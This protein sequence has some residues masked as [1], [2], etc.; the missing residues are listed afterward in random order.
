MKAELSQSGMSEEEILHKT[1]VLMKAFGKEDKKAGLAEFSLASKQKNSA[2]RK[3]D[4][5]PKD[6]SQVIRSIWKR[7]LQDE[8]SLEYNQGVNRN[9]RKCRKDEAR[10]GA[11]LKQFEQAL[12]C[13]T[14][15]ST[16]NKFGSQKFCLW[17]CYNFGQVFQALD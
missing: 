2:L 14:S 13:T 16:D 6:F 5:S 7:S 10:S 3:V 12:L 17:L 1:Q 15:Y 9:E 8:T 4:I 11:E